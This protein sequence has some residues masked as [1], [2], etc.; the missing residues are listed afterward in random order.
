[1]RAKLSV[2]IVLVVGVAI[3][4][5]LSVVSTKVGPPAAAADQ[6][7]AARKAIEEHRVLAAELNSIFE[8]AAAAAGPSVVSIQTETTVVQEAP[9]FRTPFDEFFGNPFDLFPRGSVPRRQRELKRRG[10]GSGTI[11]D[12]GGH[13]LTNNHVVGGTDKL[14]V[15]LADGRVFDAKILGTDEATDLALIKIEDGIKALPVARLGDSDELRI[16][17]WVLAL[18]NPFG[19]SHTVSAGIVSATGRSGMRML[20]YENFIQ[21]D[22]AIN[23]GNSGGPLVNLRGEV[24]GI[25]TMILS[26]GRTGGN[27][28][29]GLT[30][31]INIA[32]AILDDL[33]A[34]KKVRRGYLGVEIE[35]MTPDRA[36]MFNYEGTDGVF[37]RNV[38]AGTPADEAGLQD[39]DII[40]EFQ[41]KKIQNV[42]NLRFRVA[43]TEPGTEVELKVWRDGKQISVKLRLAE[44]GAAEVAEGPGW[45]GITVQTLTPEMAGNMGRD[46]L[47]GVLVAEVAP[48]S[49]AAGV[50]QPGDIILSVNRRRVAEARDFRE[51]IKSIP[52]ERGALLR[53]MNGRTGRTSY[54]LLRGG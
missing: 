19:L 51:A 43:E 25:N 32:K 45:L 2:V 22:A 47:Q 54:V 10:L 34:G 49:P 11:L 48:D 52:P 1:M 9:E 8:S 17:H 15:E 4:L 37:V 5:A 35:N 27:V 3:G 44:L 24:V 18:G 29:I 41:G 12:A 28:G 20:E 40:M 53:V 46:G 33:K 39:G 21:T 14:K 13:I 30:V 31:P 23:P 50:V 38:R 42:N 26:P 16:G 36:E 6:A 7:E